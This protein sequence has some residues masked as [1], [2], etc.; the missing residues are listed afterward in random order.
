MA[1]PTSGWMKYWVPDSLRL[2]R[3]STVEGDDDRKEEIHLGFLDHEQDDTAQTKEDEVW[4]SC[5]DE[6]FETEDN[7]L[8]ALNIPG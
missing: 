7:V 8:E 3:K 2:Q 6:T 5:S 1:R 4:R